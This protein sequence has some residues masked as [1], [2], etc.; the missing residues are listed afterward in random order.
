MNSKKLLQSFDR[1]AHLM[2]TTLSERYGKELADKLYT[3]AR[4]EY[5]KIIPEIPFIKGL[6]AR[7]L[8]AFLLITAQELAVF[9]AMKKHGKSPAEAW[10]L[11]HE[12]LRLRMGE[13]S[14]IKKWLIKKLM[15]SGLLKKR[16]KMRAEGNVQMKV[17]DFEIRYV[18]GDAKEFDWG[19]DYV[20]CGNFNLLKAQGA[21][22]FA[23]YVCMS[24]IAL[25]DALEWGL[26]RTHTIADGYETCDFRFKKGSESRISSKTPEVQQTIERIKQQEH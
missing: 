26:I 6:R 20:K 23:P 5:E 3:D 15:F 25:G 16:M 11:C 4:K 17:G 7:A 22:E 1:T 8:N 21:E 9:K 14:K 12:A 19:V 24:D 13:Y 18:I 10:E 2:E